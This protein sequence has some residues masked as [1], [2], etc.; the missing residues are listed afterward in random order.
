[1]IDREY[2]K[3]RGVCDVC[4]EETPKLPSW[5]DVKG[6]MRANG[7]KTSRNKQTEEWENIS[8]TCRKL[9]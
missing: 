3:Y 2:G 7:W 1:M 9:K 4:G 8:P 6:Y 5:N